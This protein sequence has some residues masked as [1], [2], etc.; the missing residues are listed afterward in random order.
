MNG[1][2][3]V[4]V[5]RESFRWRSFNEKIRQFLPVTKR[6]ITRLANGRSVFFITVGYRR[7]IARF[8]ASLLLPGTRY[9]CNIKESTPND[10]IKR[11]LRIIRSP[12]LSAFSESGSGRA[13]GG[14]S[15][16]GPSGRVWSFLACEPLFAR[17]LPLNPARL[18]RLAGYCA[19][20]GRRRGIRLEN[21]RRYLTNRL[22]DGAGVRGSTRRFYLFSIKRVDKAVFPSF[23]MNGFTFTNGIM[24]RRLA[25]FIERSAA[26][27]LA[28]AGVETSARYG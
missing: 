2:G 22:N 21:N 13:F 16:I 10:A 26:T 12:F 20:V 23:I 11:A 15:S 14:G 3:G 8:W 5:E 25:F 19:R 9:F 28:P 7:R 6:P 17:N 1:V 4:S 18:G 24:E 27:R